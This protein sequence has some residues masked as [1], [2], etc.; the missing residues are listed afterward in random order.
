MNRHAFSL[1]ELLVV[2][3]VMAMLMALVAPT[4]NSFASSSNITQGGQALLDQ[5]D[6]A[7]QMADVRGRT[8]E[9]RLLK[10]PGE[11]HYTGMQLFLEGTTTGTTTAAGKVVAMP[12]AV[13]IVDDTTLSPWLGTM[14]AGVMA[15]GGV[16]GGASYK[17][18]SVR[19]SGAIEPAPA[20]A[21]RAKL[22]LTVAAKRTAVGTTP[23]NYATVQV[24][25][26][27]AR[28]LLYRP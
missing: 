15:S 16:W 24:N 7:Q 14:T 27:T 17:S 8:V 5:I 13:A 26:D 10:Q 19:P 20:A 21:D 23:K 12:Q 2:I 28:P 3:A 6:A 4:F 1:T 11:T 9:L 18:F 22:F 25:P